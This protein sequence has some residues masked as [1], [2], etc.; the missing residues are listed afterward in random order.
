MQDDAVRAGMDDPLRIEAAR[1]LLAQAPGEA[2]DRLAV[3]S[4]RLL[5]AAHAQVSVFTDEQVVLTPAAARRP[6]P[7]ALAPPALSGAGPRPPRPPPRP[8]RPRR[9]GP[10]PPRPPPR[11]PPGGCR[12]GRRARASASSPSMTPSRSRG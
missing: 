9:G 7:P 1:R 11:A 12:P 5:G 2:I 3:L 6:P 4:A 8:P 10:P